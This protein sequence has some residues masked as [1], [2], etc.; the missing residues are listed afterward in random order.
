VSYPWNPRLRWEDSLKCEFSLGFI[1][2]TRFSR[3][4]EQNL[5][6]KKRLKQKMKANLLFAF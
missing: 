5:G 2:S 4:T 3:A 6:L 1:V